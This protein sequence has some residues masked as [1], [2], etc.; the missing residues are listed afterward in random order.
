M[1]RGF[2]FQWNNIIRPLLKFTIHKKKIA[3]F[4]STSCLHWFS[5]QFTKIRKL[6]KLV[7]NFRA[8]IHLHCAFCILKVGSDCLVVEDPLSDDFTGAT[9]H[10][11]V[12]DPDTWIGS[13][14]WQ[15]NTRLH[16]TSGCVPGLVIMFFSIIWSSAELQLPWSIENVLKH[17]F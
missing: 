16:G 4:I 14:K 17:L 2:L 12:C 1:V 8:V 10:Y 6:H 5:V 9:T 11:S 15:K 7:R 13:L 3:W